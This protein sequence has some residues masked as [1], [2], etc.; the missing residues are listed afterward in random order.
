MEMSANFFYIFIITNVRA[1]VVLKVAGNIYIIEG[2]LSITQLANDAVLHFVIF[3]AQF[4]LFR[5]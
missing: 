4:F 2:E 5:K 1:C 3:L